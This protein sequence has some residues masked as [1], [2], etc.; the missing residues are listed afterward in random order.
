MRKYDV[1]LNGFKLNTIEAMNDKEAF[2][3]AVYLYGLEVDIKE[4]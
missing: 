4:V 1:T 3:K 2:E